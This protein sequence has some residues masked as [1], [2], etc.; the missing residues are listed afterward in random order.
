MSMNSLLQ[1]LGLNSLRSRLMLLVAL[2]ITPLAI[3]TVMGGVR[4]R[5]AAIRASEENLQR[6][7]GMAAAN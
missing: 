2:A 6:L 1:R 3:M 4:E 7:T 5:A